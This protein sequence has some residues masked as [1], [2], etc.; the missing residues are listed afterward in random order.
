MILS[1]FILLAIR[2]TWLSLG[3]ELTPWF[4]HVDWFEF[5]FKFGVTDLSCL[6]ICSIGT[7]AEFQVHGSGCGPA[8]NRCPTGTVI[9]GEMHTVIEVKNWK[10]W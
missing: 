10:A 2:Q 5:L 9:A 3:K 1:T 7:T 8:S 6:P 4:D